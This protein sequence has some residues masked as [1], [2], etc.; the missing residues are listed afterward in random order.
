MC[1]LVAALLTLTLSAGWRATRPWPSHMRNCSTCPC[2]LGHASVFCPT[3][4]EAS[5]TWQAQ[6]Q[7]LAYPKGPIW[8]TTIIDTPKQQQKTPK[9][10]ASASGLCYNDHITPMGRPKSASSLNHMSASPRQIS[11][12]AATASSGL[13]AEERHT[14]QHMRAAQARQ[15]CVM[16]M[17]VSS[18]RKMLTMSR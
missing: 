9:Q 5:R 12:G 6:V 4:R 16:P 13:P 1:M 11:S 10:V 14:P 18:A 3:Q 2:A 15:F 8:R 7:A 17:M